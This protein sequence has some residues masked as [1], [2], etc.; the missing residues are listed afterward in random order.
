MCILYIHILTYIHGPADNMCI[1]IYT[2][3]IQYIRLHMYIL[4]THIR[5]HIDE[6]SEYT[7]NPTK[8]AVLDSST[9]V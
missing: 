4:S 9:I 2:V 3:Y 5:I 7:F 6:R 8:V 1:Y